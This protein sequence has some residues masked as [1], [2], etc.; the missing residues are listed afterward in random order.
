MASGIKGPSNADVS[1]RTRASD[2]HKPQQKSASPS[3]EDTLFARLRAAR[4]DW[5]TRPMKAFVR[6]AIIIGAGLWGTAALAGDFNGRWTVRLVTDSGVC[7]QS[8][9][10]VLSVQNGHVS[11]GGGASVSGAVSSG[12]SV[13]LG[14]R[15]GVASGTASGQLRGNA[16]A[17]T[18]QAA[19]M[20][21]GRWTARK[22]GVTTASAE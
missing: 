16:G 3:R 5:E 4:P 19:G 12:G 10:T 18:W 14:I 22:S 11:G 13:S 17:G 6:T 8:Y 21:S 2:A 1:V 9:N 20:C 7:D 15:K